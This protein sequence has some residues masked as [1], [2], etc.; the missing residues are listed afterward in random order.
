MHATTE[1]N[2]AVERALQ[3]LKPSQL[4]EKGSIRQCLSLKSE[5]Q[6]GSMLLRTG[7]SRQVESMVSEKAQFDC[8]SPST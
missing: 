5:Q 3:R 7:M 8:S 6:S 2:K 1:A 4:V